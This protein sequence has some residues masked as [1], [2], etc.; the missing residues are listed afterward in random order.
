MNAIKIKG[1]PARGLAAATLGFFFG[2]AAMLCLQGLRGG[3]NSIG[4]HTHLYVYGR[5]AVCA[6]TPS[7]L[8]RTHLY[9]RGW[10]ESNRARWT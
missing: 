2:S 8:C 6:N 4:P 5:K 10:I 1:S 7:G 3:G 9:A